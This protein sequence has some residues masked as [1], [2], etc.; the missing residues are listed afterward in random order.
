[1]SVALNSYAVKAYAEHPISMWPLD[2][3]SY[4]ISYMNNAKR[5]FSTWTITTSPTSGGATHNDSPTLPDIALPFLNETYSAIYVSNSSLP[6]NTLVSAKS[7]NIDISDMNSSLESFCVNF[8]LYQSP[9][10]V[11]WYKLGYEYYDTDS[12]AYETILSGQIP[13]PILQSWSNFNTTYDLPQNISYAHPIKLIIQINLKDVSSSDAEDRTF[14]MNG[15]SVGQWSETSCNKSLGIDPIAIPPSTDLVG[16]TGY[17]ADQY[18]LLS[19]NG[20]YLVEDGILLASNGSVPLVFGTDNATTLTASQ[21]GNPSLIFPGMGVL[22]EKGKFKDYSLEFWMKVNPSTVYS[23]RIL[24]PLAETSWGVYVKEGF[25]SLVIG[26][27]RGSH[28]VS[29]WNRP[30][31]VHILIKRESAALFINGEQV[32]TIPYDPYSLT[33]PSSDNDWWGF[34]SYEDIDH[35]KVDCI[36]IYPYAIATQVAKRRMAWG[37]A[38]PSAQFIDSGFGGIPTTIDFPVSGYKSNIIYPDIARW[39]GG[40]FNNLKATTNSLTVPDYELPT[41]Y[42]G[43]R[44]IYDW[45]DA[46]NT[47]NNLEYPTLGAH[48]KFITFR[49]NVSG[50]AWTPTGD[51]WNED[52]YLQFQSLNILTNPV[53]AVYGVFEVEDETSSDRPLIHF[54]NTLSGKRFEINLFEDQ[55]KYTLNNVELASI[56]VDTSDHMVAGI[57]IK[58]FA[59]TYGYEALTFFGNPS[60]IQIIVGG[61]A[62]TGDDALTFDEKIYRFG[63]CNEINYNELIDHFDSSGITLPND[64]GLFL[65]HFA[66]Y[67]LLP[68]YEY[69]KFF[70]DI[71]ISAEWEE[72]YPLSYFASPVIDENGDT[73]YDIDSLQLNIGYPSVSAPFL[74]LYQDLEALFSTQTY[75]DLDNPVTSGYSNYLDLK[76][77][78]TSGGDIDVSMSSLK[79]YATF[80]SIFDNNVNPLDSFV[81]TKKLD[82]SRVI[83]VENENT[84][85]S[86]SKAFNTKFEI[87]NGTIMYPPKV[88]NEENIDFTNLS[89]AIHFVLNQKGILSNPFNVRTFEIASRPLSN[90]YLLNPIKTKFG[91]S[92]YTYTDDG[93]VFDGKEQNPVYI[94]KKTSPYLYLTDDSGIKVVKHLEDK[95]FLASIAINPS[96]SNNFNVAAMQIWIKHD[97]S[98]FS[99]SDIPIFE[100]VNVNNTIEIML[101]S[102]D[103]GSRAQIYARDKDTLAPITYISFYQNGIY[104][105]LPTIRM[106]DWSCLGMLFQESLEFTNFVGKI[107]LFGRTYFNNISYYLEESIGKKVGIV[108]RNWGQVYEDPPTTYDWQHWR[109]SGT[110]RD[111]YVLDQTTTYILTPEN[112][113]QSYLGTNREV[114]DDEGGVYIGSYGFSA[115]SDTVWS[116]DTRKPA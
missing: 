57:N 11:N 76:Y 7:G 105:N 40:Y 51:D 32:I 62:K 82:A 92:V 68:M 70:L 79:M 31:I 97:F 54:I 33:F 116:Q 74:F 104:V 108:A 66:S 73:V 45:Y 112:I 22:N 13:P 64:N 49:P 111:V 37:Q 38:V 53:S 96:A 16:L 20:Y 75:A 109:D 50:G 36:S 43:G 48:P 59:N 2:D 101:T 88:Y 55:I 10:Y 56:T 60:A 15:L 103:N 65:D 12:L 85:A 21:L 28:S 115:Y 87:L 27:S 71:A 102:I 5:K 39:D 63:F 69:E 30:M 3:N 18:G 24:G 35:F 29:E 84:L 90:D 100:I 1:M 8:F 93:T 86:P 67:T 34:Y 25:I 78:N 44:N 47:V 107:N 83:Y 95:E 17:P 110:W 6:N 91:N 23:R 72:Y 99:Q 89:M 106:G 4:Y 46:N 9:Q 52:C 94:Y 42:L 77:N 14:I 58:T 19:D 114:I 81:Y 26:N 113:Y 80:Q 98:E 41:I 61:N